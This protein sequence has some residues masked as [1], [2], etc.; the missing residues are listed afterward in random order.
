MK[1]YPAI[2]A[3]HKHAEAFNLM[4]YACRCGHR[5]RIWNSRD[6]V[7]PFG[8]ACPS[9]GEPSLQHWAFHLDEFKPDHQP[10][11]GQRVWIGMTRERAAYRVGLRIQVYQKGVP[12]SETVFPEDRVKALIEDTFQDGQTPDLLIW[13]Y[14]SNPGD[15]GKL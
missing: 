7:T 14:T 13:G 1:K 15:K 6:G 10:A 3:G 11:F 4:W 9:C 2:E 8:T 5:E 12:N